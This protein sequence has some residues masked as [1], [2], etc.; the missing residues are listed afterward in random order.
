MFDQYNYVPQRFLSVSFHEYTC[1]KIQR[2]IC[3]PDTR[4][5]LL[6]ELSR[7]KRKLQK[8]FGYIIL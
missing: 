4:T 7:I 5:F 6:S 3:M 8:I 2:Y 1:I